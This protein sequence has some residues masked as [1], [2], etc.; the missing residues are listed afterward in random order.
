[1]IGVT[2]AIGQVRRGEPSLQVT[3][4][5]L[6]AKNRAPLPDTFHGLTDVELRYRKRYLDLL[7]NEETRADFLLRS[8]VV[9]RSGAT[10]TR[11]ASSRSR[12]RCCS[13]ATEAPSRSR[14]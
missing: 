1:M 8:R 13:R 5:E 6:L 2:W 4:L 10:W 3:E 9:A 7:M 11:R 12:H 14:S